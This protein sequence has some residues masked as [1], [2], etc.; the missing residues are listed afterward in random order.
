MS[1]RSNGPSPPTATME[2]TYLDCRGERR[3]FRLEE[4][5]VPTGALLRA[6]EIRDGEPTGWSFELVHNP[7]E[8]PPYAELRDRIRQRLATRDLVRDPDTGALEPLTQLV[9]AQIGVS[10]SET[11]KLF[12]LV[13]G[14]EIEW[15]ELG[16]MLMSYEGFGL[17]LE[18]TEQGEE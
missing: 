16:Q 9:R 8:V 13:D 14:E 5:L 4:R 7:E 18:I 2:D 3:H 17:R 1:G 6:E 10:N 12:L 15:T 11:G